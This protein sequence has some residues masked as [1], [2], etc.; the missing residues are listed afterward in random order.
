M[1]TETKKPAK[2]ATVP[3]VAENNPP[4]RKKNKD[5]RP[6]EYLTPDEVDKLY[7]VARVSGPLRT[8]NV[9]MIDLL[10]RHA[11]RAAEA[12]ALRW[13]A[14]D[15][16]GRVLHV[17]RLK[18]GVAAVHPLKT[19][20]LV[21]L[22]K[23]YKSQR[24]M[25]F[26]HAEPSNVLCSPVGLPIS[27]RTVHHTISRLGRLAGFSWPIHPHMLR[28]ACG[29]YLAN[30]GHDTRSIQLYLGHADIKNTTLY[31]VLDPS[32]FQLFFQ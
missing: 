23:L 5:N 28:H 19:D 27:T 3:T 11:L 20:E 1:T 9:V 29:Y 21:R 15:R 31:T 6:R 25:T 18:N 30:R 4:K 26:A 8:R 22:T 7:Q 10:Y 17:A 2:T 14:I 12:V 24:L 13:D 16:S 32:R